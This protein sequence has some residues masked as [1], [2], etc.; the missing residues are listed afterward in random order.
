MNVYMS[1]YNNISSSKQLEPC[2]ILRPLGY[3]LFVL[4]IIGTSLNAYIL[5]V[6]IRYKNLRQSSTNIFICGLIL[7][8]FCGALFE[9]PLSAI[10]L[11]GCRWMFSYVGCVLEAIIAYFAGCSN[12]YMLCLISIDRYFV[13]TR[14]CSTSVIL[15]KHAYI[16]VLC[17]YLLALFWTLLPVIGWSSYDYEGVGASCS[18]KWEERSLNVTSYN[19]TI[20]I[21]VYLIPVIIIIV[22][23]ISAFHVI[24]KRRRRTGGYLLAWTPY[25]IMSFIRAFTD[26]EYFPP[27][28][29][30]IPAFFA[31]TS[32]V[33]NSLIYVMRNG[34]IRDY[35]PFCRNYRFKETNIKGITNLIICDNLWE[36]ATNN[37]SETGLDSHKR[38]IFIQKLGADTTKW[39]LKD[40]FSKYPIE[41]CDV[42]IDELDEQVSCLSLPTKKYRIHITNLPAN[43]DAETLS[44]EFDWDIYDIV[45]NPSNNDRAL[46][47]ECWLKNAIDEREV[48]NFG[49]RWNKQSIKGSIIQCEKEEDEI[50][51]CNK[52]QFGRCEKSS[53]E[54]H[55]EHIPCTANGACS[56]TCPYGHAFGMKTEHDSPNRTCTDYR[57]KITGFQTEVTSQN[58]TQRFGSNKYYV[59]RKHD[60]IGYVVKIKTMKYAKQL[61]TKWHNKNI[62]GQLIKCQLELNPILFTHR[63]RSQSRAALADREQKHNRCRSRPRD[64]SSIQSSQETSDLGDTDKTLSIT[65]DNREMERDRRIIRK[66]FNDITPTPSKTNLHHASSSESISTLVE[67]KYQLPSDVSADEWEITKSASNSDGKV[68]LIRGKADRKRLAVIKIYPNQS[69]KD[70]YQE[71]TVMKH[72]KDVQGVSQLIEPENIS[73]NLTQQSLD[74]ANLWMIMK[75]APGYSLKEFIERKY[76]VVLEISTAIQL[77]LNLVRILQQVHG[78]GIFHQ[79]LSPENIMIEWDLNSTSIDQALLTV[80]NFRH[81]VFVSTSKDTAIVSST[82]KWYHAPQTNITKLSSTIDASGICAILFWLLTQMDPRRENDELPHQ[83]ARDKL[84][85]M[86]KGAVNSTSLQNQLK[87]YLMD[88]FDCAFGYPNYHPWTINDLECRLESIHQLLVLNVPELTTV[89]A[90]FQQLASISD[91]LPTPPITINDAQRDAFEKAA[92]AFF[93]YIDLA[94]FLPSKPGDGISATATWIQSATTVAGVNS[95]G[96]ALNQLYYPRGLFVDENHTIHVADW[97]NHRIVKWYRGVSIGQ[98]VAGGHGQ[99]NHTNQLN[100]SSDVLVDKDETMYISDNGN[101]RILRWSQGAQNG[102]TIIENISTFGIAQDDQGSLYVSDSITGEVKKWR[103]GDT[104]GQVIISGLN[105]PNTLFIDRNRSVYVADTHNHRVIKVDEGTTQLSIVAGGS[106]GHGSNH[107]SFPRAVIVDALGTVYVADTN[108]H[109]LMRWPHGAES[110]S[111]IIGS[112][113]QGS[114]SDQLSGPTDLSFDLEGNLYVVDHYNHR[115]Q[116]FALNTSSC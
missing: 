111:V 63:H 79:N 59:D 11:V 104:I 102:E 70:L 83:Q 100:E 69:L 105:Q 32:L 91:S 10:A 1:L 45:M 116:K 47:T 46:S 9:I 42:P 56:L 93:L 66:A 15:V 50:E 86:I 81:A 114:Q 22:T 60:R 82:Q 98:I 37:I 14:L 3:Y 30:T 95:P 88:T 41:W 43:I 85:D 29:G 54:C 72:L 87:M 68:L 115:V 64:A 107:L 96:S 48:N 13:V 4:W 84:N 8:D 39:S 18:V 65:C 52:F 74:K 7:V 57:I 58:L 75:R 92:K 55:W 112:R 21:F 49:Q 110:G 34:N 23:N 19:L 113:G 51:F 103:V 27:I 28:L 44:Q 12:M 17:G 26:T 77:T 101:R 40:Y 97:E 24:R 25:S 89:S 67:A 108:N 109:R 78:R 106:H 53:D 61:M 33:W 5:Y 76:R 99:G 71:I 62:D 6:F 80:L 35:L 90:I 2:Y 36:M 31:K 94:P 20:F 73:N 38:K 16:T